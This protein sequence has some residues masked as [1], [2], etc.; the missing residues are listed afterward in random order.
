MCLSHLLCDAHSIGVL[1]AELSQILASPR[2]PELPEDRGIQPLE[3]AAFEQSD[4]GRRLNER[5]WSY[6]RAQLERFPDLSFPPVDDLTSTPR[7]RLAVYRCVVL[8]DAA[9]LLARRHGVTPDTAVTAAFSLLLGTYGGKG[10]CPLHLVSANRFRSDTKQSVG[11]FS[12]KVPVVMDVR[13]ESF[14][15][16][17]KEVHARTIRAYRHA[18]C[19]P[20]NVGHVGMETSAVGPPPCIMNPLLGPDDRSVPPAVLDELHRRA[21]SSAF[22]WDG[23]NEEERI[24]AYMQSGPSNKLKFF[25]DTRIFRPDFIE[26]LLAGVQV[27]LLSAIEGSITPEQA[28]QAAL[29]ARG[30]DIQ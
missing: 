18:M 14:D 23:G 22:Q 2:S 19:S 9:R 29:G 28:A 21:G 20:D 24:G 25:G 30:E 10:A 12:L 13:H 3:Q 27:V 6:R 16:L 5:A 15:S 26:A 11:Q 17:L 7:F 4:A 8:R 1:R